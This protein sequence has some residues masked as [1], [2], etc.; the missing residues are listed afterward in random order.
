MAF[1]ALAVG[2]AYFYGAVGE[3]HDGWRGFQGLAERHR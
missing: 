1:I 2:I 3:R